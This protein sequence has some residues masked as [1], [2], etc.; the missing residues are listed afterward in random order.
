MKSLDLANKLVDLK[1]KSKVPDQI[2]F[3]SKVFQEHSHCYDKKNKL[4]IAKIYLFLLPPF[5]FQ[6]CGVVATPPP[7]RP[8]INVFHGKNL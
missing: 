3:M 8:P 1:T 7:P 5:P 6:D 2:Y 4:K